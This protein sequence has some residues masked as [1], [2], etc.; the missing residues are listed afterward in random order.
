LGNNVAIFAPHTVSSSTIGAGGQGICGALLMRFHLLSL[1]HHFY[2]WMTLFDVLLV[3]LPTTFRNIHGD[4]GGVAGA[5]AGAASIVNAN[6]SD[7]QRICNNRLDI[8][9]YQNPG[10]PSCNS[11]LWLDL[12]NHQGMLK[13]RPLSSRFCEPSRQER[14]RSDQKSYAR[15]D[16]SG[17]L[18]Y[19]VPNSARNVGKIKMK[20]SSNVT[21]EWHTAPES[22]SECLLSWS[23]WNKRMHGQTV[24][25]TYVKSE[26]IELGENIQKK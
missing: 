9:P 6:D 7:G 19:Y 11:Y 5:G 23:A 24:S 8:A 4:V 22:E 10:T 21:H 2:T 1:Y 13:E 20:N 12:W 26:Y 18:K 25:T 17:Y 3:S 16:T 15:V 14:Q